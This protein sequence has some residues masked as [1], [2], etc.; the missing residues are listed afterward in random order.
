[1][2]TYMHKVIDKYDKRITGYNE[3][4]DCGR[5][6][7]TIGDNELGFKIVD[8]RIE[9]PGRMNSLGG[10]KIALCLPC[11]DMMNTDDF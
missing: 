6:E 3:C 10:Y 1:M 7:Y 5:F 2:E 9:M 11:F 8:I 4:H